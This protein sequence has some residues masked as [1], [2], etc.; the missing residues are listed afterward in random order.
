MRVVLVTGAAGALGSELVRRY[1]ADGDTVLMTDVVAPDPAGM[2]AV[3]VV[4]DL[5]D[6]DFTVRLARLI[7]ERFGRL[8]VLVNCAGITHRSPAVTTDPDIFSRIMAVNWEAPIRLTQTLLPLLERAGG[9][10]VNLGSMAGW[11]PVPGRAAYGASK[12]ALT[13]W[14]EVFRHEARTRGVHVL[15]VHPSFLDSVMADAS[16]GSDRERSS[17]GRA[18][19]VTE[20]AERIIEAERRLRPWVYPDRMARLASIL[21]RMWP[22]AYQWLVARRFRAEIG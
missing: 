2:E 11:M 14:M 17:V 19:P 13:Q 8:D 18:L 22:S 10:V 9:M 21:W 3:A 6:P 5:T 7:E 12:A 16:G 4:G 1:T 15:N 20:M